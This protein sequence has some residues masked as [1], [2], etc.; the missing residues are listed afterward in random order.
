MRRVL[1]A[2]FCFLLFPLAILAAEA[3]DPWLWLEDVES[4]KALAWVEEFNKKSTAELEAV[5][6]FQAIHEKNL[7]IYNSDE[8]IPRVGIRG[9]YLYNFW[10]DAEHVR[11]IWRRTTLDEY[12]RDDPEW[13]TVLDVDA[14][15]E[16]EEENWVWKGS[17]CLPP[18][19]ELCMV[20]LSRGGGDAT[21]RREFN[22][23]KK[24]FVANGF[25]L[26]EAKSRV[27]WKDADTLWVGT[28]TGEGSLTTSGY[29][30]IAT[31]W[32]RGT[33]LEEARVVFEG[34]A[35]DVSVGAY[36][37]HLPE[38]RYDFVYQV[39]EFFRSTLYF[40]LGGRLVKVDIPEDASMQG[41]FKEQMLVSLRSDWTVGGR[42]YPQDALLAIGLDTFLQGG[43]EFEVL[44]EP[45]ERVSLGG[46][47]STRDH[48]LMTTL[49]N[50]RGKMYRLT[51]AEGEWSREEMELPGLGTVGIGS[52]TDESNT[53][54][55]TYTD[56]LE[57]SSLYLVEDGKA[58]R[59][60]SLPAFF[61]AEG[62]SVV[63]YEAT[64]KDGTKIPYFLVKPKGFQANGK[65][66]TLLYGY[67]GFE[68]SETASYSATVGNAW[69]ARGGVYALANIR[70]GGEFGP[71]WHQ[72]ALKSKR[73]KAFEDFIAVGEDLV[74]RNITSPE[75]L[76]IMGG[77]NGG[78]LVG[79]A[80]TQRP[81]LFEA[82]VCQVPLLDMK[83][84]HTLL[85]G[86]SW[87]AEY[88]NPDTEDWEFIKTW[89]PY[90]NL[91]ESKDYP[92]VFFFTSTRDDRVHPGHARKMVARMT[93]MGKP[94]YY[95]ENTEGGH[96]GA[97]NNNQ[98]A[99]MWA[100]A[101]SYLW[102]MLG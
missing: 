60:K 45:S 37:A 58:Q 100:L 17:T 41:L 35:E 90:H 83:R 7:E 27:S 84:Y 73:H 72:A 16:K 98:R 8:R 40:Q 94:V 99:Y 59:V 95:Y 50:V 14:L 46:V 6:V 92:K 68:V 32:K 74:A 66:P 3:E 4:A 65:N 101:Y 53:W 97:A 88:G 12:R 52:T 20:A 62:M 71:K 1:P 30:R 55:F 44:F 96:A 34:R 23:S 28:D 19:Y 25:K 11:G 87:M 33:P 36:S 61:D 82:V 29:P 56:F 42:T 102:K 31:E 63:Q 22:A 26:P 21:V 89:S 76:G 77:S 51:F 64:S 48:V 85:A 86:A 39:P 91:D 67:G 2:L 54:F 93:E 49:D 18:E 24:K 10:R 69:L 13:E 5:P 47:A 81:D 9:D 80:F 38:G 78:L 79:A 43:R 57:P 70:G 75:H 15:A